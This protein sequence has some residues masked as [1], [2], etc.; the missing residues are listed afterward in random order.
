[1]LETLL[2]A[3]AGALT[4]FDGSFFGYLRYRR[5]TKTIEHI[6]DKYGVDALPVVRSIKPPGID[7]TKHIKPLAGESQG[8]AGAD[9]AA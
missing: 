2:P 5:Y 1:M 6:V 4:L 3:A 8:S 7:L 9:T